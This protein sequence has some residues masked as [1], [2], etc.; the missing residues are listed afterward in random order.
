[1]HNELRHKKASLL[2][3]G[4]IRGDCRELLGAVLMDMLRMKYKTPPLK[5][6]A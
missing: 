3:T 5:I 1:V 6:V 2:T 4:E